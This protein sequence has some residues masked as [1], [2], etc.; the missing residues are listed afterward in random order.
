MNRRGMVEAASCALMIVAVSGCVSGRQSKEAPRIIQLESEFGTL[1]FH[2]TAQLTDRGYDYEVHA[3]IG[4]TFHP[5]AQTNRTSSIDLRY[6]ELVAT[7]YRKLGVP[8]NV[9][10][11]DRQ[12]VSIH[13][14]EAN[15]TKQL[16]PLVFHVDRSAATRATHV[17]LGLSDGHLAWPIPVELKEPHPQ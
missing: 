16:P 3:N 12:N 1:E 15:E 13:L 14:N 8:A 17:G 10:F 7:V 9:L 4:V 11:R 2:G 5:E 6:C